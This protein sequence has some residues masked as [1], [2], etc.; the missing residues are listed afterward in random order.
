[1]KLLS[2]VP[3]LGALALV[4]APLTL[5]RIASAD[6]IGG[7][8]QGWGIAP[9]GE[10]ATYEVLTDELPTVFQLTGD[11]DGDIDCFALDTNGNVLARDTRYYDGCRLTVGRGYVS[12]VRFKFINNGHIA[13]QYTVRI[14]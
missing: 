7:E 1:M 4:L 2:I 5:T 10:A 13:S 8:K 6:P 14:Y 9:P 11:G 3:F 12:I